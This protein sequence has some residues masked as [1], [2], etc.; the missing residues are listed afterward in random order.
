[1]ESFKDDNQRSWDLCMTIRVAK[2]IKSRFDIDIVGGD[3]S[4]VVSS[5][6]ENPL[7][8]LE[9]MWLMVA[10]KDE[11]TQDEF[12]DI[13]GAGSLKDANSAF[14]REHGNFI[15]AMNPARAKQIEKLLEKWTQLS[16]QQVD[17]MMELADD[18]R[19]IEAMEVS[20]KQIKEN[21]LKGIAGMASTIS[22]DFS[23]STLTP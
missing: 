21:A 9:I 5:L 23:E 3:P 4:L 8:R 20:I 22:Q 10:N 18:P 17:A 2:Q 13:L 16:N 7:T 1:V 19:T 12:D 11:R 14:W 15:R 6:S